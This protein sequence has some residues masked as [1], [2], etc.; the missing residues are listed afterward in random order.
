MHRSTAA[1]G[2][3]Q[4]RDPYLAVILCM[5]KG[6]T[7]S[8]YLLS[9]RGHTRIVARSAFKRLTII[10]DILLLSLIRFFPEPF[11]LLLRI[12]N[13]RMLSYDRFIADQALGF[14]AIIKCFAFIHED[15]AVKDDRNGLAGKITGTCIGE[16]GIDNQSRSSN[17]AWNSISMPLA[18]RSMSEY[19]ERM[20][21]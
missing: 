7:K 17:A 12:I 8:K 19:M 11:Q 14:G 6:A 4:R 1:T 2:K 18:S 16:V 10:V 15:I 13:P 21:I 3:P 5:N 20:F 9:H